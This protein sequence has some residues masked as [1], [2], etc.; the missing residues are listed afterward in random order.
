[1]LAESGY[2]SGTRRRARPTKEVHG[3]RTV[4]LALT[5]GLHRGG[6]RASRRRIDS[7][8]L[9]IELDSIQRGAAMTHYVGKL[10]VIN[11]GQRL[12]RGRCATEPA[13]R[14]SAATALASRMAVI[15]HVIGR[16][17]E[18]SG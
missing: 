4:S 10:H 2:E 15:L 8:R 3:L 17:L 13:A 14:G 9:D 7:V 5:T 16:A 6:N 12:W 11:G 18:H 1:M